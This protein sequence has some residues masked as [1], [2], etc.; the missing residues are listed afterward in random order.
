MNRRGKSGGAAVLMVDVKKLNG[1]T[2]ADWSFL[3]P[4]PALASLGMA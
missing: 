2:C 1:L 4:Q 3:F